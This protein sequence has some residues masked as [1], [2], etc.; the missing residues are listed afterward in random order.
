[1]ALTTDTEHEIYTFAIVVSLYCS[2][3][4]L[5]LTHHLS[6]SQYHPRYCPSA[7]LTYRSACSAVTLCQLTAEHYYNNTL[8]RSIQHDVTMSM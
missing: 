1:M 3:P 4:L 7:C 8:Q 5:V 2:S 6:L